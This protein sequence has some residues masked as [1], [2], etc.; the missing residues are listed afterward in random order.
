MRVNPNIAADVLANLWQTQQQEQTALLQVS[1]GKRVNV[2]SDDPAAAA[3]LVQNL[4]AT[5]QNDQFTQN[6]SVVEGQLQT[7]DSTLSSVVSALT[8]A[9]SL[10]VE[11]ANGTL[12]AS[13][14]QQVAAQVQGI[15]GQVV[16]LANVSYQGTFVFAGT[17]STAPPFA[18]D[19][20]QPSGVRYDGN[21][22]INSVDV[23]PGRSIQVNLPGNQLFQSP[24]TDVFGSLQQLVTALQGGNAATIATATTQLRAAFD[25]ITQQRVF[26]GNAINQLDSNQTFLQQEK[27][28]LQSQQN[29]LVGVDLSVAATNLSQAETAQ[30]AALAAAAKIVPLTLLDY[31]PIS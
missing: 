29:D 4:A 31:L 13:N 10:G 12:S 19:S 25:G 5:S 20:T 15:I 26:Y 8:Q 22:G 17:A 30:Q 24:G 21:S 23:A 14:E 28:S 16:Q 7:A 9:I 27:V 3:G 6:T 1:S 18:L 2:P 11:G